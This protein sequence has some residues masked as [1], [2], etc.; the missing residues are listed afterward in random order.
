[1]PETGVQGAARPPSKPEQDIGCF[2]AIAGLLFWAGVIIA[3][4]QWAWTRASE[5]LAN[6]RAA[7]A[8]SKAADE[9]TAARAQAMEI[10]KELEQEKRKEK[11]REFRQRLNVATGHIQLLHCPEETP[12]MCMDMERMEPVVELPQP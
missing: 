9:Q 3:V 11:H 12:G 6:Y 5:T 2:G 7:A 1:M 4:G 10:W 8:Q